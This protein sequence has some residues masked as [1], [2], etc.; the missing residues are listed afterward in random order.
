MSTETGY[1]D[2]IVTS[3]ENSI[4]VKKFFVTKYRKY[5]SVQSALFGV[6][7]L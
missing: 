7:R 6:Y 2:E 3:I 1:I 5:C 4:L